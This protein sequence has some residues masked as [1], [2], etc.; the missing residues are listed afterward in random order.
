MNSSGNALPAAVVIG[1]GGRTPPTTVNENDGFSTFD[2]AEDGVDFFESL[3]GMLVTVNNALVVGATNGFGETFI[4]ADGGS[5]ATGIN[6]RG[7]IT[8]TETDTNPEIIQ[9]QNDTGIFDT[10]L[11]TSGSGATPVDVADRLTSVT[12]V[13]HYDFGI[14]ELKPT[15]AVAI[16]DGGLEPETTALVGGV[17]DADHRLLQ[18]RES[19][20]ASRGHLQRQRPKL[21]Q[22][23][24]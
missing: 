2:P 10:G 14:Y 11:K 1:A 12:G 17:D 3:E 19:G 4:V 13:I 18:Q 15:Q 9:I 16:T 23:G 7:G 20:S 8:L 24:R 21:E 22:R 6:P 5:G